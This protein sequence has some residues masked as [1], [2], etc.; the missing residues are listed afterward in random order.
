VV[1]TLDE[2]E[3]ARLRPALVTQARRQLQDEHE[4]E[5]V[6]QD[7]LI[8]LC[9][10]TT[11]FTDLDHVTAYA[12]RTVHNLCVDR[13]RRRARHVGL[14]QAEDSYDPVERAVITRDEIAAVVAALA[15]INPVYAR[16]LI[17][18]THVGRDHAEIAA[19]TGVSARNVRHGLDRGTKAL[20]ARLAA[21][22]HGL[23]AVVMPLPSLF[24]SLFASVRAKGPAL[25]AAPAVILPT[26]LLLVPAGVA[27]DQRGSISL[28]RGATNGGVVVTTLVASQQRGGPAPAHRG[29]LVRQL[30]SAFATDGAR[31]LRHDADVAGAGHCYTA[32]GHGACPGETAPGDY[33][34]VPM[35]VGPPIQ[36][37]AEMV[38][39]STLPTNPVT[40]CEPAR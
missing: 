31:L 15:Q 1:G 19:L 18:S 33:I 9:N 20:R 35:P 10:T 12:R 34:T 8:A 7:A 2:G 22:G 28:G 38:P 21:V 11:R 37:H 29:G 24:R 23:G 26:F 25:V 40:Q 14:E 32:A 4:A 39:C 30:D 27:G 17:A 16:V 13:V 36:A 5:D 3:L 6:A